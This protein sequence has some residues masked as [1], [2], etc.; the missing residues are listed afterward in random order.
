MNLVSIRRW[1]VIKLCWHG[2]SFFLKLML[3]E[4][5]PYG[6]VWPFKL[7]AG[8]P[9]V[10]IDR[11]NFITL[12]CSNG[13]P[14][15]SGKVNLPLLWGRLVFWTSCRENL[16]NPLPLILLHTSYEISYRHVLV[17][18]NKVSWRWQSSFRNF[19]GLKEKGS[20]KKNLSQG[21]RISIIENQ[22]F[23]DI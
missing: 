16:I 21:P 4:N 14:C 5:W 13:T 19:R 7:G 11:K 3:V 1:L 22:S 10:I 12:F 9:A 20:K 17:F 18:P 8:W 15:P 2:N 23:R 6:A